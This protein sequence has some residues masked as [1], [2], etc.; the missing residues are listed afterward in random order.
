MAKRSGDVVILGAGFSKGVNNA[1]LVLS[2]LAE[3]VLHLGE[4][5][6]ASS[7][8]PLIEELRRVIDVPKASH[9]DEEQ[10]GSVDFEGWH[11][12]IAVDQPHLS[13]AEN[14]ERRA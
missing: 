10:R 11:S 12:R 4:N 9:V 3:Q 1:F 13:L 2:E 6:H 7:T 5:E 14:Y 8:P